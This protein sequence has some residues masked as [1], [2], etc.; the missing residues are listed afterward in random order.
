MARIKV[1]EQFTLRKG[2]KSIKFEVGEHEVSDDIARHPYVLMW[3]DLLGSATAEGKEK[4]TA[5]RAPRKRRAS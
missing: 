1:R 4:P 3:S 2:E 5:K